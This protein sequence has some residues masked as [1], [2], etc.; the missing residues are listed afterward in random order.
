MTGEIDVNL[1]AKYANGGR[2]AAGGDAYSDLNV[3]DNFYNAP[4]DDR[5]TR[6][7]GFN[8]RHPAHAPTP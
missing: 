3:R 2:R 5:P 7:Q 6:D 8:N 4:V 1:M